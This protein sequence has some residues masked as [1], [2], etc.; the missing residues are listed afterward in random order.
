MDIS[1]IVDTSNINE[2]LKHRIIYEWVHYNYTFDELASKYGLTW[3]QVYEIIKTTPTVYA[4]IKPKEYT[5]K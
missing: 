4:W 5:P 3:D 1:E 2:E